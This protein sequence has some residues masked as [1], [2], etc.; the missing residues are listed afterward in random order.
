MRVIEI[1]HE[2]DDEEYEEFL[3]ELYGDIDVCGLP[4][5]AGHVLHEIDPIAFRCGKVEYESEQSSRWK[6]GNC[7]TE[8]DDED[9]AEDCCKEECSEC[10]ELFEP[11]QLTNGLCPECENKAES[12][13]EIAEK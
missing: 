3:N 7:G 9:E 8:Y 13:E 11:D 5:P 12:E 2:V 4:Y 6:C 1:E 10:Y